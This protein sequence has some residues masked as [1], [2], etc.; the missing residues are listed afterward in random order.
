MKKGP[1]FFRSE[2]FFASFLHIDKQPRNKQKKKI[3]R[4]KSPK[5]LIFL[6]CVWT[7]PKGQSTVGITTLLFLKIRLY[8]VGNLSN[9]DKIC[10]INFVLACTYSNDQHDPLPP[11]ATPGHC[12][13]CPLAKVA[14]K[15]F[16]FLV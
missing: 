12:K 15:C 1:K 6:F 8:F 11:T 16:H 3:R 10:K 5:T 7:M 14:L 2:V 4:R 13:A 9:F